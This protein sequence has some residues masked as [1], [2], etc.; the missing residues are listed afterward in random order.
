M[1][2]I[3]KGAS[4]KLTAK[5]MEEKCRCRFLVLSYHFLEN[6]DELT[7]LM[8]SVWEVGYPF[9]GFAVLQDSQ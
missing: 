9:R 2:Q 4:S 5:D 7:T 6:G 3:M 1:G 8:T